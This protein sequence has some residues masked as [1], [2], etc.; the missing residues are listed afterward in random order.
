MKSIP[1][2]TE[3][4]EDQIARQI[5]SALVGTAKNINLYSESH[6]VYHRALKK[7]KNIFEVYFGRFGNFRIQIQRNK[8]IHHDVI[9]YEGHSDPLDLAFL[10]HRDGILWLEFRIDL[11]LFEIDTFFRILHT[12]SIL[13]EEPEDDIVT[14]LWELNLPSILYAAADLELEYQDNLNI[15]A[16][17]D[18]NAQSGG[19]EEKEANTPSESIYLNVAAYTLSEA[20]REDLWQL[21]AEERWQL[22]EMIAAEEKLDGS[23]YVMDALLYI[24]ENHPFEEDIKALLETLLQELRE[25]L[26]NARFGYLLQTV[27][28]LKKIATRHSRL[29]WIKPYFDHLFASLSSKPWL[30]GLLEIA[31]DVHHFEDTQIEDLKRFLLMLD[32]S[33]ILNMVPIARNIRSVELQRV[34]LD[35]VRLMAASDFRALEKLISESDADLI[36]RIVPVLG[37]LKNRR[38]RQ[39]LT[40]LLRHSSELVRQQ[41][42]KT[43]LDRDHQAIHDIFPLIDDPDE[44]IRTFVLKRLGRRRCRVVEGKILEYLRTYRPCGNNSDHFFA[45]CRTLGQ[46]GS[47]RSI[48]YLSQLLFKWPTMGILRSAGSPHRKGAVAALKGL[49]SK[50][51]A[52]LIEKHQRGSF[53]NLLKSATHHFFGWGSGE[54]Q[55]I[56]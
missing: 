35:A 2:Q 38:S 40:N 14:A 4:Q 51:A 24:L 31:V 6:V 9:M 1:P 30:N 8:I 29:N 5:V 48:P 28:K 52:I 36:H 49:R 33:A 44:S 34:I 39:T 7:L 16:E 50:K 37:F 53:G 11:E 13:T 55:N 3:L 17:S 21:S 43:L 25:I 10:L 12:H 56:H 41:A 18:S 15:D 54:H 19:R 20:Y 42:L 32:S 27:V 45:L 23:D 47:E 26:T 46:C 22:Q